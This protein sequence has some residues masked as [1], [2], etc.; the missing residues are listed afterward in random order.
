MGGRWVPGRV[1][2]FEGSFDEY[3]ELLREGLFERK[4]T[5]GRI[6]KGAS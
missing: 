5:G 2:V 3:R 6:K 1:T 4:L